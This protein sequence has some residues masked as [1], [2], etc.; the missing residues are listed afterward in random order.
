MFLNSKV[1]AFLLGAMV[2]A[3]ACNRGMDAATDA[4]V[5]DDVRSQ[6]QS[7]YNAGDAALLASLYS[8]DAILM[9]DH[10]AAVAGQ[11]AIQRYFEELFAQYTGNITITPGDTEITGDIAHEHGTFSVTVTPKVGGDAMMDNGS[12]LVILK[13][14]PEG[15]WKLH[16][17]IDNSSN[18]PPPIPSQA[19]ER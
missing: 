17:A 15:T 3:G 6:Y 16:H 4:A 2:F 7:A 11:A 8:V 12:Y 5:I 19:N 9:P 18:P 13:R 10:H 14:Q 1:V